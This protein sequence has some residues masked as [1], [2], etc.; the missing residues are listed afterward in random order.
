MTSEGDQIKGVVRRVLRDANNEPSGLIVDVPGTAFIP[1]TLIPTQYRDSMER[2]V[3]QSFH[4]TVFRLDP[5][6]N[7]AII[8]PAT[9]YD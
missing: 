9:F 7:T 2:L 4:G 6:R 8:Q 5:E 1:R 3:G